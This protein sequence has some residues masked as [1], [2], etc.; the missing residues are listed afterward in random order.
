M[1]LKGTFTV[2]L[3]NS[4]DTYMPQGAWRVVPPEEETRI[5]SYIFEDDEDY[6]SPDLSS[7]EEGDA[8]YGAS[9]TGKTGIEGRVI[10][11]DGPYLTEEGS[12]WGPSDAY[13]SDNQIGWDTHTF[14]VVTEK[15]VYDGSL[16]ELTG[17]VADHRLLTD[18]ERAITR[19]REGMARVAEAS[20]LYT[21]PT[22]A[23]DARIWRGN[24]RARV[25]WVLG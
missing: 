7:I 10:H 4:S 17:A 19:R 18:I 21:P 5:S 1:K 13:A 16:K 8:L 9:A 25:S 3:S 23:V 24:G 2:E 22:G 14:S 15:A 6:V 12:A 20:R 11:K